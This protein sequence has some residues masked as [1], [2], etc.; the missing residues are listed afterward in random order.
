MLI[1]CA[2]WPSCRALAL[3]P[4]LIRLERSSRE[5]A[6]TFIF[7]GLLQQQDPLILCDDEKHIAWWW[8][9]SSKATADELAAAAV[10]RTY[11]EYEE[12]LS[13]QVQVPVSA[14][15]LVVARAKRA[16]PTKRVLPADLRTPV[17][18][19][20]GAVPD[21]PETSAVDRRS[22]ASRGLVRGKLLALQPHRAALEEAIDEMM[23]P[24]AAPKLPAFD[25]AVLLLFLSELETTDIP[26]PVACKEAV[27]LSVAYSGDEQKSHR[28]VN[29]LLASYA[30]ERLGREV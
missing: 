8:S 25:V 19:P 10:D 23:D 26:V 4:A 6:A 27:A 21:G 29:G 3:P 2:V 9:G 28:H 30:R 24:L 17:P 12:E 1:L 20:D 22:G 18:V 7:Q 14:S 13:P 11:D 16:T 5:L 15:P